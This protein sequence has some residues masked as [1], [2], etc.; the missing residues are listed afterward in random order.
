MFSQL[1]ETGKHACRKEKGLWWPWPP[2]GFVSQILSLN[3]EGLDSME[4]GKDL[5]GQAR[6]REDLVVV[7]QADTKV[8]GV[9][10]FFSKCDRILVDHQGY[11]TV[12]QLPWSWPL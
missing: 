9:E 2:E 7:S 6:D 12:P 11:H 3:Q 4:P 5:T 10:G 8:A 1:Q